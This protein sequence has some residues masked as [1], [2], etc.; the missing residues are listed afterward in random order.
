MKLS[1]NEG[2]FGPSPAAI[3]AYRTAAAEMHRYPD[4]DAKKLREAIGRRHGLDPAR[5]V[6]G[7]GSDELLYLLARCYAGPGDEILTHAHAFSMYPIIAKVVCATLVAAPEKKLTVD[8]D[9]MLRHVSPRTRAVYLANPNNPTGS[10]IPADELARLRAGLRDD[11]LLVIDAAYAEYVTRN[12]YSVGWDLVDAGSNT[13]VTRSFSKAYGLGGARLGFA[14]CPPAIVDVLNRVR[15]PFNV[16]A[17]T[18]AAGIAALGDVEFI[19]RVR[20]HNSIWL[21]W[22]T[23]A[24]R[25][26][27]LVVHPSV[28]NF[29]LVEFPATGTHTAPA[30]SQFLK[31]R[32]IIV[33]GTAVCDLPQ[34]LRITIGREEEMRAVAEAIADFMR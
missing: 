1:S 34:C 6:C 33:R 3:E 13:V 2:A 30:A 11:I 26:T 18:Q 31:S 5:I 24:I 16:S 20:D 9:G 7:S 15:A 21:P 8:V 10:Y 28:A 27:G 32:G 25:A 29:I 23:D 22:L 19:A 12:D 17:G 4:G 14:Y